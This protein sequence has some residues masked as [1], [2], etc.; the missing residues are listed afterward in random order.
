LNCS[1]GYRVYNNVFLN[2][3]TVYL[4]TMGDVFLEGNNYITDS[5]GMDAFWIDGIKSYDAHVTN[6]SV[7][8]NV[9]IGIRLSNVTKD[10]HSQ[11]LLYNISIENEVYGSWHDI[12]KGMPKNDIYLE[13]ISFTGSEFI[14]DG[15][16]T[17]SDF[18]I[19]GAL[20]LTVIVVIFIVLCI[21][22]CGSRDT[23]SKPKYAYSNLF[24]KYLPAELD[25]FR[26]Q[27]KK[28]DD[29]LI[30]KVF[31]SNYV[32]RSINNS[33]KHNNALQDV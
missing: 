8:G 22:G 6:N 30:P 5:N 23:R 13:R 28:C 16:C 27:E 4:H 24:H 10:T 25:S 19:I 29:T 15:A 32:V 18:L 31:D 11:A 17:T 26:I 12:V 21:I 20:G 3:P 33:Y 1:E 9:R 7:E 2:C 14:C